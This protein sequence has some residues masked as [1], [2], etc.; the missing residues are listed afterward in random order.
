MPVGKTENSVRIIRR[1]ATGFQIR[2]TLRTIFIARSQQIDSAA[3]LVVALR[4][5]HL[6]SGNVMMNRPVMATEAGAV[7]GF[8]RKDAGLL[9]VASRAIIGE[10]R[11]G[12]RHASAAINAGVLGE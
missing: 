10:H 4:A 6:F 8:L 9:H 2:M 1:A 3:M 5:G 7:L 11:V 12:F